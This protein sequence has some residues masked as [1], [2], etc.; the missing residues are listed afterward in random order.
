MITMTLPLS[1]LAARITLAEGPALLRTIL[2]VHVL[3][4]AAGIVT[5][6]LALYFPKGSTLHRR[7]GRWFVYA[8]VTMGALAVP[9]SLYEAKTTWA[10]G[11]LAAYFVITGLTTVRP[12]AEHRRS[13]LAVGVLVAGTLGVL[14][15]YGGLERLI[16]GPF[17]LEGVPAPMPIFLGTVV[18]LAVAGDLR[19]LRAGPLHGRPR[20]V[21]HLWRMC[22]ALWIAA[23]SFFI[24]QAR[25]FPEALRHPVVMFVPP[26]IPLLAM[27]YWIWRL[28]SRRRP[29]RVE[30]RAAENA[31]SERPLG[32]AS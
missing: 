32:S 8:M 6:Y 30:I 24:G 11:V 17:F 27:P 5:G 18:L 29:A 22:F 13:L 28:R 25:T 12:A 19:V 3:A 9:I 21:R 7:I 10:G 16:R 14:G 26:L 2:L 20:L 31:L 23:G 4:G 1:V 15:V